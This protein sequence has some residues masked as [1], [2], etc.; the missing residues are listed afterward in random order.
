[1]SDFMGRFEKFGK[2]FS[3]TVD[4]LGKKAEDTIEIQKIKNQM[5]Q[6]KRANERDFVDV[7]KIIYERYKNGDPI[8]EEFVGFCEE[9]AKRDEEITGCE[10]EIARIKGE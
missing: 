7:G 2:A 8:D 10:R 5:N 4:E 1:M 9:I 3:N 6:M